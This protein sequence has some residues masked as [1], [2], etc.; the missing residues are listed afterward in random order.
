MSLGWIVQTNCV[1]I[2]RSK[3][4]LYIDVLMFNHIQHET[5]QNY[6]AVTFQEVSYSYQGVNH[7][8]TNCM[9]AIEHESTLIIVTLTYL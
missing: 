9:Q 2:S 8:G 7:V 1:S 4:S 5:T 6:M 3:S